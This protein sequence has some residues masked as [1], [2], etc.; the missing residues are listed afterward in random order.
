MHVGIVISVLGGY[1][2]EQVVYR[3][4]SGLSERR[5]RVDVVVLNTIIHRDLP[6]NVRLFLCGGAPDR[7]TEE[8]SAH[9]LA[10]AIQLPSPSRLRL[11]D[12]VQMANLFH[13]NL[14]YMPGRRR[15]PKARALAAYMKN[16]KPD[17]VL[18]NLRSATD[19]KSVV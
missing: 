16:E 4:A 3:L 9:V 7:L 2:A 18:S 13:W 19:R 17:C 10:R 14:R 12:W 8:R 1:G 11:L 5:H 15:L 6:S